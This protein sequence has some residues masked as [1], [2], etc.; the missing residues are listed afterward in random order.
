LRTT[1]RQGLWTGR[2][3]VK[4]ADGKDLRIDQMALLVRDAEENPHEIVHWIREAADP[5][6]LNEQVFAALLQ[7]SA[8]VT[9]KIDL[10]TL[11]QGMLTLLRTG[12]GFDRAGIWRL[13]GQFLQGTWGTREDGTLRDER[14]EARPLTNDL[15]FMVQACRHAKPCYF[16][17]DR[18]ITL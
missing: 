18:Q 10:A 17:P 3:W 16:D 15:D 13:D 9:Q 8:L 6:E 1:L 12:I 2:L 11:L 5:R 4:R 7:A 14:G